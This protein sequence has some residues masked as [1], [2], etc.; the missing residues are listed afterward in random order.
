MVK[1]ILDNQ[2]IVESIIHTQHSRIIIS[3]S[4]T[5]LQYKIHCAKM[6]IQGLETAL[7]KGQHNTI[8]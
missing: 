8:I 5:R 7:D 3:I 2:G 6:V 1:K 4:N